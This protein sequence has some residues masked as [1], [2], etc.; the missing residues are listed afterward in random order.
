MSIFSLG[1]FG[2]FAA[3]IVAMT[4]AYVRGDIDEASRQGVLAGPAV[5]DEALR[6]GVRATELSGI[7]AAPA[8]EA[9]PELLPAL[10]ELAGSADRRVAIPA[11]LAARR[12]A[13][14]L[15]KADL[16][17]DID[18]DDVATWRALFE[19]IARAETRFIEVRVYAL[20]VTATL[21]QTLAPASLGFDLA[22]S[23][24]DRDPAFRAAAVQLVP[25]P[26]PAALRSP[27]AGAVTDDADT[28]VAL[29]AA[30]ALCG[31]HREAALAQLG[32]R[33]IDRIKKLVAGKQP[34]T[35]RDAMKCLKK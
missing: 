22:A 14:D 31:D 33:G 26:T 12:I 15:A 19:Q 2:S 24:R 21:T 16:P 1:F 34:R 17:D 28:K 8:V 4:E 11:A 18:D 13:R 23:L 30:Q 27:L 9:A 6:S 20:D 10:A 35:T 5:V 32:A 29:G 7:A 3:G 25:R